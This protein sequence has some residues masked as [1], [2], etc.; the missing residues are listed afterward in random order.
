MSGTGR[1]SDLGPRLVS[2][3]VLIVV[4]GAALWAGGAWFTLLV[5]V[6]AALACWE[7][8]RLAGGPGT[9]A[10]VVGAVGAAALY[11]ASRFSGV[12]PSGLLIAAVLF[13]APVVQ[14]RRWLWL[15]YAPVILLGSYALIEFRRDGVELIGWLVAVVVAA[16]VAGYAI[17]RLVGGP[18]FWPAL[19]PKKTW[20]GTIAGW[21]AATAV[22]V[23]FWASGGAIWYV[24]LSP[25]LAFA[26]QL[27]DI[28][29]SAVKR[30]AGVKD[31]SALIPGHGGIMDRFDALLGAAL[32]LFVLRA[33][34][35]L[36]A[37]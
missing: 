24:F 6:L 26:A 9:E 27:G 14:A 20:S 10:V 34:G 22:G 4:G 36:S 33:F 12:L 7:L 15:A 30:R 13:A 16:D 37:S 2:A 1:W 17:G 28:G 3:A 23:A 5:L 29:E 25:V 21:V 31:A 35:G 18:K 32:V 11:L 19:S 8:A